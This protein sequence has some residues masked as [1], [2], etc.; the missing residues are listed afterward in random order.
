MKS[1]ER[2]VYFTA[3]KPTQHYREEHEKDV[4]WQ[5]VVE[6]ILT[7]KSPR[8]KGEVYQIEKDNYYILFKIENNTLYVINA[9]QSR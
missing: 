3:I 6:I 9:K 4:P 5:K 8:K 2:V 1:G 7:T